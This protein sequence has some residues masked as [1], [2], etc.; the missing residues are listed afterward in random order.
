MWEDK[1]ISHAEKFQRVYINSPHSRDNVYLLPLKCELWLLSKE[2][3]REKEG[4]INFT[5]W[6]SNN[7]DRLGVWEW[8]V[9]RAIFKID[10]Q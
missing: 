1:Q 10:N 7:G 9:H 6:K 4:W 2:Y 5:V 8:H 3:G